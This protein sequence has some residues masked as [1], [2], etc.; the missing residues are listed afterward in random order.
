MLMK[1]D[2]IASGSAR[3]C[4]AIW[5]KRI[6]PIRM[7]ASIS[8]I[9][10]ILPVILIYILPDAGGGS[11]SQII[12]TAIGCMFASALG[13]FLVSNIRHYPGVEESAYII[14]AFLLS[15]GTLMAMWILARMPY[16]RT[17][18]AT[19]FLLQVAAFIV[20][21]VMARRSR[22]LRIGV[23]PQGS[24]AGLL[25]TPGVDWRLLDRPG[26]RVDD[27]DAIS[28]D[29]WCDIS[30]EWERALARFALCGIPVYHAKHL[31]ESLTGRVEV[32]RLS[33]N[34]F[35]TLSPLQAYMNVKQAIDWVAALAA[36]LL[37]LPVFPVVAAVIRLDS[38][39][40]AIFRQM[41]IG[42]RGRPF[43]VY[44]FRTMT[45]ATHPAD[46]GARDAAMTRD[47]DR[48]ITRVGRFLRASRLDELPQLLNV[49]KGEMSWIGPRPEAEVLSRWYENEIPFYHYR[50]IVRPGITG[51]AQVNQ[52]HVTEV[53]QVREKLH[54][55]FY[56]IK[57]FSPWIDFIIVVRTVQTMLSGFGSR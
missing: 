30:D 21:H 26:A 18:L 44:K 54:R 36:L 16:S 42:Y 55:D 49:L 3:G 1:I 20:I 17:L 47:N 28:A 53:A 43:Q 12:T 32:E 2:S 38:P 48:R 14:P 46:E 29:L 25:G 8:V 4:A 41:R 50:H 22:R 33:E 52:G 40:P 19:S 6:F 37:L 34:T 31:Q 57:N 5:A 24:Y 10:I 56:Y 13:I 23:V 11:N 45:A 27:L 7:Q 35:G 51:W 9:L 15:Y 39:G